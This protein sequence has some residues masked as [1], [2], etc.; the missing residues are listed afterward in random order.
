MHKSNQMRPRVVVTEQSSEA[1][2]KYS[3]SQ[4]MLTFLAQ[5][6]ELSSIPTDSNNNDLLSIA[7]KL[8]EINADVLMDF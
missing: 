4:I 2:L 1:P 7:M 6:L 8:N 5:A 3:F